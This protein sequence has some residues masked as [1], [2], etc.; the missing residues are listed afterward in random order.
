MRVMHVMK[1][2]RRNFNSNVASLRKTNT[3]ISEENKRENFIFMKKRS[4]I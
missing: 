3:G 2:I 4:D 1:Q